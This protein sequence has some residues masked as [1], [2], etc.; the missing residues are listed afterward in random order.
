MINLFSLLHLQTDEAIERVYRSHPLRFV[1][2]LLFACLFFI[3]PFFFLFD[4]EG[5]MWGVAIGCWVFG[6]LIGWVAFDVWSS[7]LVIVTNRRVLGAQRERW[8]RVR[9]YEW[10]RETHSA[11]PT[12]QPRTLVPFGVLR[13]GRGDQPA[14]VLPWSPRPTTGAV[15]RPSWRRIWMLARRLR[16]GS[17]DR[18]DRVEQFVDDT[19]RS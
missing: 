13:W 5:S 17:V 3:L 14:L 2:H 19:D 16:A 11:E 7:S 10:L 9:I 6:L 1:L 18:L 12:W 8:G 4:Y 15:Q